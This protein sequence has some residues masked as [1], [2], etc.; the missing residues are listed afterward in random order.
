[1]KT[2]V[3]KDQLLQI[4]RENREKHRTVFEAA[5]NGYRKAA[6]EKLEATLAELADA[7][8]PDVRVVLDR[9]VDHTRDYD[10]VI[11]MLKMDTGTD[12]T[13]DEQMFAWFVMDDW[14]WKRRWL[15]MS[16]S[17]AAAETSRAYGDDVDDE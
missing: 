3:R 6:L 9:P 14:E 17:Y 15:R 10:R 1:M 16:S 11:L 5:L 4:L 7:R 2:T 8:P 13:L 12:F